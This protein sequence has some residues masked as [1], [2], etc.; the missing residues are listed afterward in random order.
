MSVVGL[1]HPT[2]WTDHGHWGYTQQTP[3][4]SG[5]WKGVHYKINDAKLFEADY[6]VVHE[7]VDQT[8]RLK[9]LREGSIL[10]TGEEKSIKTYNQ[11]YLNQFDIVVTSRDDIRHHN[12]IRT[13]YFHPWW[14]K[15]SYDDLCS[16]TDQ[17]KTKE[18][19][20]IISNLTALPSHRDRFAFINKLK[21]HYKED[22]D[23]FS[24]GERTFLRDKWDGLASYKYSIAIEN[25]SYTNYFTEKISDCFLAYT[26]PVYW[27]C[28]NIGDFFDERSFVSVDIHDFSQAIGIIDDIVRENI[29]MRNKPHIVESRRLVLEKYHFVAALATL[30]QDQPG[31]R[32]K[33]NKIIRPQLYFSDNRMVRATKEILRNFKRR[34]G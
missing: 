24:K 8:I 1:Y 27:G 20:A 5:W 32:H 10:V 11:E 14:V 17:E 22:L 16:I 2:F 28:P 9:T 12:M 3:A 19:S 18:L 23:W 15:K 4:D 25:S 13:H 26:M 6:L 31:Q 30:I 21:G 33:I 34:L 29:W 7:D